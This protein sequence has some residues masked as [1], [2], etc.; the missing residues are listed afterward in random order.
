MFISTN[1]LVINYGVDEKI[2]R[3]FVDSEPPVENLILA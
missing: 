3:F 1:Y 2:A